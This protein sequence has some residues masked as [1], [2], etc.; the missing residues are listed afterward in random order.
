VYEDDIGPF[1]FLR[2]HK[3][4][5][6]IGFWWGSKMKDPKGLLEG[7]GVKMRHIKIYQNTKINSDAISDFIKQ[8]LTLNKELGDP[9]R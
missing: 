9:S 6:N 2:A 4:H 5:V 7:E 3:N 8:A 1:C